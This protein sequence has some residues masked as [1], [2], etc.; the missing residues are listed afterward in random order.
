MRTQSAECGFHITLRTIRIR[1]FVFVVFIFG[2]I[3]FAAQDK[4]QLLDELLK[5]CLVRFHGDLR[6]QL[7]QAVTV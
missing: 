7:K 4:V 6:A 2:R 1:F 5:P 3:I